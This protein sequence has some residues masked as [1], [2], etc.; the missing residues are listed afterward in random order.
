MLVALHR[1]L[2]EAKRAASL[3]D[4][5][6]LLRKNVAKAKTR[7]AEE[8]ASDDEYDAERLGKDDDPVQPGRRIRQ[9][10]FQSMNGYQG[11]TD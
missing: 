10:F 2:E 8:A 6:T 4:A 1:S 11:N 7:K 3:Q 5:E 9:L